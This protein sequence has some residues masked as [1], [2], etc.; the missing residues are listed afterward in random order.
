MGLEEKL[1]G[2]GHTYEAPCGQMIDGT[3]ILFISAQ[4]CLQLSY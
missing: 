3:D 1:E 4:F 2:T